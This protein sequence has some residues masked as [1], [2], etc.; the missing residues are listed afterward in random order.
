MPMK[1][2]YNDD[3][4]PMNTGSKVRPARFNMRL[5]CS[6]RARTIAVFSGFRKDYGY[7]A[8]TPF[9]DIWEDVVLLVL[10]HHLRS[11]RHGDSATK[12]FFRKQAKPLPK[13]DHLRELYKRLQAMFEK[14]SRK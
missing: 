4:A 14:P 9:A 8:G 3:E 2:T 10:E 12:E 6:A 7:E 5:S 1:H 13:E 11:I